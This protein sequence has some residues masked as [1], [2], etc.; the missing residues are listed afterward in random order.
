MDENLSF[1]N[2]QKQNFGGKILAGIKISKT[3]PLT[4]VYAC[5]SRFFHYLSNTVVTVLNISLT[6][7]MQLI[8]KIIV[9][10]YT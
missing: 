1:W 6:T 5:I 7:G 8:H 2:F 3:K 4:T 9:H 10:V